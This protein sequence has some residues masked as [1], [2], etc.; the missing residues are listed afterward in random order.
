MHFCIFI[1]IEIFF[2]SFRVY[3]T[4]RRCLIFLASTVNRRDL[5]AM[6]KSIKTR[7][8]THTL[9]HIHEYFTL[10]GG[11]IQYSVTSWCNNPFYK[12]MFDILGSLTINLLIQLIKSLRERT[13][14]FY[15]N[16]IESFA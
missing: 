5:C 6:K 11:V 16:S 14:F 3:D 7:S 9:I 4:S 13:I 10:N 2:S 1:S 15:V 8:V 12:L